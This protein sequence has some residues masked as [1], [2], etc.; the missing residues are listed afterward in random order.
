MLN[1]NNMTAENGEKNSVDVRIV[2]GELLTIRIR[3]LKV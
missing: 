3:M 1:I 2:T